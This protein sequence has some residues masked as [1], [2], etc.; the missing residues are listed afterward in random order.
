MILRAACEKLKRVK[1]LIGGPPGSSSDHIV[2]FSTIKDN[3][4]L[5]CDPAKI[6]KHGPQK[7]THASRRKRL[8]TDDC[9][10]TPQ[11]TVHATLT[12]PALSRI[13]R[14]QPFIN[15]V[16]KTLLGVIKSPA[17]HLHSGTWEDFPVALVVAVD[18]GS[19][20]SACSFFASAVD[21]QKEYEDLPALLLLL[22]ELS[23]PRLHTACAASVCEPTLSGS[24]SANTRAADAEDSGL[25]HQT[26]D[27]VFQLV[28]VS[29][30]FPH[31]LRYCQN[32]FGTLTSLGVR[33]DENGSMQLLTESGLQG[34]VW[35]RDPNRQ[36]NTPL[37]AHAKQY[38]V[39]PGLSFPAD[40]ND[41]YVHVEVSFPPLPA[42]SIC[43]RVQWDRQ[44][45][46]VSTVFSY[47]APV[48]TNE[49]QLRGQVDNVKKQV[50]LALIVHGKHHPYKAWFPNDGDW[51]QVCVTWRKADGFWAI[52]VDGKKRDSGSGADTS[53]DIYENGILILGQD[54]DSFGG[55]FTEP[56]VGNITDLN[57]WAEVLDDGDFRDLN[58]CLQSIKEQAIF[59]FDRRNLTLHPAVR[60]VPAK[61]FCPGLL[62]QVE[63]QGCRVLEGWTTHGTPQYSPAPCS[64]RLP[65]ICKIN[66]DCY[67]KMKELLESQSSR[68]SPFMQNLMQYGLTM[69]DVLP[70]PA[71]EPSWGQVSLMLNASH[72]ALGAVGQER[73]EVPDVISLV[74]ILS[75][76]AD[77]PGRANQSRPAA[78][79]LCRVFL[80]VADRVIRHDS[81]DAWGAIRPV[82][83]GPM[84]VVQTID[85]MVSNLKSVL[86]TDT[87]QT[88]IHSDNIR[89]QVLQTTL[90]E[91]SAISAFCGSEPDNGT[92]LD[93]ISVPSQN[94]QELHN[95]GFQKVTVLNTWYGSL[96]PLLKAE[97][98]ITIPPTVSDGTQR[99]K[100]TVLASSVI[101]TTVLGDDQPI[102][103]S[104]NFRLKHRAQIPTGTTYNPVC[105][106]WD[107][108]LVPEE[109]GSWSTQGCE[110]ISSHKDSTSC[111]CNHT[112]NFAL[113]LQIYE[114]QRSE[115][116]ERGLQILSFI[117]CGVSL[118][119]LAFTFILFIAVGVPKSDR[120]TVHKNLIAALATAQLLLMFSDWAVGNQEACLVVTALLHLFFLASFCWMLVEGL[121]LWSKVVSVNISEER[122]MRLY[123]ALGWG[124]PV[125]IVSVTMAISLD[126]YKADSRCWLNIESN[127]IWAFVGP[128]LFVLAVNAVV[129]CRVV[130]VTVS[131]AR[132]RAKMLTPSSASKLHALDLTW[133]ATRPVLILLPVLG[134]TWLCGVLVHLSVVLAYLFISLNAFQG[135]YIFLVYAVY[136]SE[137]RNAIKR[138]QEKRKALSFTNCSQPISFLPS[139]RTPAVPWAHSLPPPSSL[140]TSESSGPAPSTTSSS[141]VFKNESFRKDSF[142]N[143][144]LKPA[145]GN[146][147]V[148]LTAFKPSEGSTVSH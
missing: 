61:L 112:T 59:S 121:L 118:C 70:G 125:M 111:Y 43:V 67:L 110:V 139:Q 23:V 46:Q 79:R 22:H 32:Q 55:N 146:Q 83:K 116:N 85:R 50:L 62:R 78:Q 114:V 35:V 24:D 135:L 19:P 16:I 17:A 104:V 141:L 8:S 102:S 145:S 53:R 92:E 96:R 56:F 26:S 142:A 2:K 132:R 86:L 44:H 41:G 21:Q 10:T 42:V 137:V 126:K 81:A 74:R 87:E 91:S 57:V 88:Q 49:F 97:E 95:N 5:L 25:I 129:L 65:F 15:R 120:T 31:A 48:F 100:G 93:C 3:W 76:A 134:L 68:P 40:S 107:F 27:S 72:R 39:L 51:H 33:E 9:V 89:L 82:V 37:L 77:V 6:E 12:H 147:V 54:Q 60:E 52:Y 18:P 148:Q 94:M 58:E 140:E 71:E 105:A 28:N 84:A 34:P 138:I 75:R 130:M 106:F 113:L 109:G 101:S 123:Y 4:P 108:D 131:S 13:Y 20:S 99:Y 36:A 7:V 133:A 1:G 122:R 47:A 90:S 136:N 63:N 11:P 80:G 29:L 69:E 119:G 73:L 66:K 38:M 64:Q 144:S 124:L 115:E 143:F 117:S 103:M 45:D 128:V 30:D 14:A 98:N 127:V